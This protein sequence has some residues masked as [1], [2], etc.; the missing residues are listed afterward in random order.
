MIV[1]VNGVGRGK[2]QICGKGCSLGKW[3]PGWVYAERV[4]RL[5]RPRPYGKIKR[6]IEDRKER[7]YKPAGREKCHTMGK[8]SPVDP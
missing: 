1:D 5:L 7:R 6:S 4:W 8:K 2:T 3:R